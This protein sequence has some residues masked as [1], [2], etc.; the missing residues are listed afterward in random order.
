VRYGGK[1]RAQEHHNVK[2]EEKEEEGE[3]YLDWWL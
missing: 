2:R 3:I 1:S